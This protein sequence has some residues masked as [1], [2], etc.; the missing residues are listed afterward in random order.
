VGVA[1]R[2]KR[3]ERTTQCGAEAS[4]PPW[5]KSIDLVRPNLLQWRRRAARAYR[6]CAQGRH[7]ERQGN[8]AKQEQ[9]FRYQH[10]RGSF[11]PGSRLCDSERYTPIPRPFSDKR[12]TERTRCRASRIV[13]RA[14]PLLPH[15]LRTAAACKLYVFLSPAVAFGSLKRDLHHKNETVLSDGQGRGPPAR[16]SKCAEHCSA[17][18]GLSR[19]CERCASAARTRQRGQRRIVTTRHIGNSQWVHPPAGRSTHHSYRWQVSAKRMLDTLTL[20]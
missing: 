18:C 10:G 11:R 8:P 16:G 19:G 14:E 3:A 2:K 12:P 9:D 5:R 13:N 1:G 20:T 15:D 7:K 6:A 4:S 17:R